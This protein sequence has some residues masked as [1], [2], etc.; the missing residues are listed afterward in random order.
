MYFNILG[1]QKILQR[2]TV[3][4]RILVPFQ[5]TKVLRNG[6]TSALSTGMITKS[7]WVSVEMIHF[8]WFRPTR[9]APTN[10][11]WS[12]N[13]YKWSY[14][15]LL[16]TGRHP[17]WTIFQHVF[18][19]IFNQHQLR[20]WTSQLFSYVH[21]QNQN[22]S[23]FYLRRLE[24]GR[25]PSMVH[26]FGENLSTECFKTGLQKNRNICRISMDVFHQGVVFCHCFFGGG[27]SWVF[28]VRFTLCSKLGGLQSDWSQQRKRKHSF[29]IEWVITVMLVI[30]YPKKGLLGE[31]PRISNKQYQS[32]IHHCFWD[33]LYNVYTEIIINLNPAMIFHTFFTWSNRKNSTSASKTLPP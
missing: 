3:R 7:S 23:R 24:Q 33:S 30:D 2:W 21:V 5:V 19:S 16:K 11:K 4:Q 9:W 27:K 17:S 28:F 29:P 14:F 22:P 32:P 20:I 8:W 15:T 25:D 18:L 10:Y 6:H 13:P 31:V 1:R 12:D 26:E